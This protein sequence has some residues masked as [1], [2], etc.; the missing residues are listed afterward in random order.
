MILAQAGSVFYICHRYCF[1]YWYIL[2]DLLPKSISKLVLLVIFLAWNVAF[3]QNENNFLSVDG[4]GGTWN[5]DTR[6]SFY[7]HGSTL[8]PA[9]I[10]NHIHYKMWDEITYPFPNFNSSGIGVWEWMNN[11][12]PHVTGHMFYLSMLGLKLIHVSKRGPEV[13]MFVE[14]I[15]DVI[16]SRHCLCWLKC[17]H[18]RL[19][20]Q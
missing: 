14:R 13:L 8:T 15:C 11:F 19:V 20:G 18:G 5:I 17:S 16:V 4:H 7:Q 10:S 12:I 6:G 3:I 9:W 2:C 1:N